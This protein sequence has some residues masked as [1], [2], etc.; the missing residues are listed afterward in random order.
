MNTIKQMFRENKTIIILLMFLM[1]FYQS[2]LAQRT[3][4]HATIQP[5]EIL[6]GEQA[7]INLKV[8]APKD[9]TIYF[10]VYEKDIVEGLE[11]LTMLPS[12]TLI[13]NN[14]ATMN[15]RY[16]V[17]SFDSTLYYVENIPV[18]DGTDTIFSNSFGLKVI[19]PVLKDSTVA[20]LEKLNTGQTD[21]IDFKQLQLYDIKPIQKPEFV[22]T[23]YLWVLWIILG[24]VV[25][26][27][28]IALIIIMVMR[29]KNKG[30]FFTPPVVLPPHA[31]ALKELDKIKQSKIWQ[32]NREKEFYTSVTD[33][34][35]KYILE[36]FNINALEMT[37]GEIIEKVKNNTQIESD[38]AV[39]NLQQVLQLAD[40]VK[41]AKQKPLQDENDLSL[42]NAFF[43][44]TQTKEVDLSEEEGKEENEKNS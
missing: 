32:Q 28:L 2:A 31:R 4:V 9:Q 15:F 11:V 34:L 24:V 41:F 25:L 29:K 30:Y 6:I 3:S 16:L 39:D 44:V 1:V 20:Y 35:R 10:P 14:V 22:W 21:S 38:S 17:T 42:M 40:M 27:L 36:R 7:V 8:I 13:E 5:A 37:S 18:F 19:S 26:V 12:D 23:D 43:F 33:V